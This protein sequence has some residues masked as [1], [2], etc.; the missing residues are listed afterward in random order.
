VFQVHDRG[1]DPVRRGDLIGPA[2]VDPAADAHPI[3]GQEATAGFFSAVVGIVNIR[4]P[5]ILYLGKD[6][7][8]HHWTRNRKRQGWVAGVVL[9]RHRLR[10]WRAAFEDIEIDLGLCHLEDGIRADRRLRAA[11][12]NA[13]VGN[14]IGELPAASWSI[15]KR[16][17]QWNRCVNMVAPGEPRVGELQF[18]SD[19]VEVEIEVR[20]SFHLGLI[21]LPFGASIA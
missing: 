10:R 7:R 5:P 9:H 8:W 21:E 1:L 15:R 19:G 2:G 20:T 3:P 12:K 4:T 17:G 14:R 16:K 13:G 18:F 11:V 6:Y